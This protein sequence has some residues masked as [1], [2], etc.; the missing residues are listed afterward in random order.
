MMNHKSESLPVRVYSPESALRRPIHLLRDMFRDLS[1]SRELAWRLFVRDT[2]A[3]YRQS[4]LGYVWA[5]LPPI[6][7]TITFV[8]LNQNGILQTSET[9]V[10]YPAYVLIGTLLWQVLV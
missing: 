9:P 6:F 4:L 1:A 3:R 5:L 10:P 7:A 2:S 8:L